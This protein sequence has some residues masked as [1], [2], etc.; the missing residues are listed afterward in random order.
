MEGVLKVQNLDFFYGRQQI[1][2][3]VELSIAPGE[4]LGILGSNGSGKTTLII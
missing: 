3:Q 4:C 2:E 1:L